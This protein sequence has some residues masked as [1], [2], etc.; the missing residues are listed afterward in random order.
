MYYN[1]ALD[2]HA[3]S[4]HWPVVP[5]LKKYHLKHELLQ[6]DTEVANYK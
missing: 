1:L 2:L 5:I 6:W 3:Q 4:W